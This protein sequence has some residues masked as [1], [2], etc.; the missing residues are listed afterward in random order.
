MRKFDPIQQRRILLDICGIS[1]CDSDDIAAMK[2][3]HSLGTGDLHFLIT[4]IYC[5]LVGFFADGNRLLQKADQAFEWAWDDRD[6]PNPK[7]GKKNF[8][9]KLTA[10]GWLLSHWLAHGVHDARVAACC[11]Q[12]EIEHFTAKPKEIKGDWPYVAEVFYDCGDLEAFFQLGALRSWQYS[13][14]RSLPKYF[15]SPVMVWIQTSDE[16]SADEKHHWLMKFLDRNVP[17]WLAQGHPGRAARWAKLAYW[18]GGRAGL[19]PLQCVL[20]LYDHLPGLSAPAQ[21]MNPPIKGL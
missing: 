18:Q 12:M 4:G 20:K 13:R 14:E 19:T 2:A 15:L 1:M 9:P 6:I 3:E 10:S 7:T 8:A 11:A 21:E 16:F 17:E 5:W